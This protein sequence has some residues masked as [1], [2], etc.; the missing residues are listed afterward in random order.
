MTRLSFLSHPEG[1][2]F[3]SPLR[4]IDGV[5]DLSELGKLEIRGDVSSL[6]VA[7]GE[8]L[9]RISPDRA[10]LVMEGPTAAARER[11]AGAGLPRLRHDERSGRAR[12]RG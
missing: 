8:E 9:V 12:G 11:L 3:A 2:A 5:T 10:L 1:V 7:A 6:A 4:H